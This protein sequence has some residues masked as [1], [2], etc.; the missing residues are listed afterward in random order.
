MMG[1]A[2]SITTAMRGK[3]RGT[4]GMVKCPCHTDKTASLK[5]SDGP[6]SLTVNC[7]A[8]CDWKEKKDELKMLGHLDDNQLRDYTPQ[9]KK[10][11]WEPITPIPEEAGPP[12]YPGRDEPVKKWAYRNPQGQLMSYVCRYES[13]SDKEVIPLTYCQKGNGQPK[14]MF[15]G[16]P[17][18]RP[19]SRLDKLS[20]TPDSGVLVVEGEKVVSAAIKLFPELVATT[21]S[22]GASAA[23]A[24][25]WSVLEGRDITIWPDHDGPRPKV[26][27]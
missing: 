6:N 20:F 10:E 25:D 24:S 8:N 9:P 17:V 3:W 12:V 4:Y 1:E 14:W 2:Q 23:G 18:P 11:D 22:G 13:G 5:L 19:L 21:S 27:R 7:Y 16:L 15:K 26:C